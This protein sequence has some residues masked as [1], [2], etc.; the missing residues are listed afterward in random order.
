[1]Y[2][3]KTPATWQANVPVIKKQFPPIRNALM[4]VNSASLWG[5]HTGVNSENPEIPP[6]TTL[7]RCAVI[8]Y[9][10]DPSNALSLTL[11]MFFY[12]A[13]SS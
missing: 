8:R 6:P 4:S 7:R 11:I 3:L 13:T 12:L 10:V 1:M 9:V 5:K 2:P